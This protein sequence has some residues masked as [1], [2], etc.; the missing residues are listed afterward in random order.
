MEIAEA[1]KAIRQCNDAFCARLES[2]LPPALVS[3]AVQVLKSYIER[4]RGDGKP[5]QELAIAEHLVCTPEA[6]RWVM[7]FLLSAESML[8]SE[9]RKQ[10]G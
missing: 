8:A 6:I 5:V 3:E 2:P 1:C 7:P 4:V 10:S 9:R